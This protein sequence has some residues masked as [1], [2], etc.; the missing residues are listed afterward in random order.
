[1]KSDM[2]RDRTL[3]RRQNAGLWLAGLV[4]I[5]LV[6]LLAFPPSPAVEGKLPDRFITMDELPRHSFSA[7]HLKW[8]RSTSMQPQ[9]QT[10]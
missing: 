1:M 8:R 6:V 7:N 4:L 10:G 5:T 3:D 2:V 9:R